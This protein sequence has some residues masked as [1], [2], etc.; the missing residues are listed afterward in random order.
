[1]PRSQTPLPHRLPSM[2][3]EHPTPVLPPDEIPKECPECEGSGKC[4]DC[5]GTGR[6]QYDDGEQVAEQSCECDEGKCD[7]C[8][9]SGTITN[10]NYQLWLTG[11][12]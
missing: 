2:P 11:L 10:A 9:G 3:D 6:V 12:R 4:I 5:G 7:C 8:C 1:M